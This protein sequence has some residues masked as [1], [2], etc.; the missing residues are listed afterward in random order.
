MTIPEACRLVLQAGNMGKGG[1]IF[2]FDMGEPVKITELAKKMIRLS[3]LELDKDIQIKFTGLRPGEKLYEEL[4]N[5]E[6]NTLPTHHS[7]IMIGKTRIYDFDEISN[8][9][10]ELIAL[11][12]NQDNT[13]IV[14]KMKEIVPEYIS[15]NSVYEKLDKGKV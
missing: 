5:S 6:E 14:K 9:I 2:L 8:H 12:K 7:Q 1:E 10:N 3:G 11:F 4:L 15:Q 13:S